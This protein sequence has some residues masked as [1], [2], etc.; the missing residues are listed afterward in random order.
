MEL[1]AYIHEEFI[2]STSIDENDV[3]LN[4]NLDQNLNLKFENWFKQLMTKSAKLS[5]SVILAGTTILV[6]L[7][8]TLKVLAI[9]PPS[10][11]IKYVQSLLSQN[12]FDPGAIDGVA[13]IST[14]N[15]ILRAQKE[16]GLTPD[17]VIGRQTITALEGKNNKE[18]APRVSVDETTRSSSVVMNLQKWS[19]G[20]TNSR[21]HH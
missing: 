21:R 7:G 20:I 16:L 14:K 2:Q 10:S 3:E 5:L 19:D 17:G 11:E 13:G 15:A 6:G 9:E 4:Q 1:L 8:S 12:G 18:A